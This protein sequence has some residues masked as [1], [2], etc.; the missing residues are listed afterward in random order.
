MLVFARET[1]R[2]M[3]DSC[4]WKRNHRNPPGMNARGNGGRKKVGNV[5]NIRS[6]EFS[7]LGMAGGSKRRI[8]TVDRANINA[9][10]ANIEFFLTTV[11]DERGGLGRGRERDEYR[12]KNV[13]GDGKFSKRM[14]RL[15]GWT[16]KEWMCREREGY[17]KFSKRRRDVRRRASR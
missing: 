12:D 14:R 15:T 6:L 8:F 10:P 1:W 5:D 7:L 4:T 16:V 3:L 17:R 2:A 13:G 11:G 9:R